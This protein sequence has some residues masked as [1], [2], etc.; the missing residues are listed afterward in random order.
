MARRTSLGFS[1]VEL[2]VALVFTMILMAGMAKVFQSSLSNFYT[3]GE[4]LSS[5]RRNRVALDLVYEDLNS[6][7]MALVDITSPIPGSD[8]N[9]VFYIIPNVSVTGAGTSDPQLTDELYMAYDQPLP[10]DGKLKSGGGAVS[11]DTAASKVLAGGSLTTGTDDAY[12]IDC[13]D[14][15]YAKSVKAGMSFHIKDDMSRA[16]YQIKTAAPASNASHVLIT[17]ET[18]PSITTQVTGRGDPG[19]L[20]STKRIVDSNVVFILPTQ[21]VRYRIAMLKLDPSNANGIPCLVREQGTYVSSAAF[22]PDASLTQVIAENVAGFKA[23]L[24]ADSGA[25][26]AGLTLDSATTG[27]AAGWTGGIQADLNTQLGTVAR[28]DYTTTSGNLNWY[29]DIPVLVRLDI[30]TR[31]ATQRGEYSSTG[32]TLAYKNLTQSVVLVPRHFGL[33]LS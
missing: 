22:T 11:G 32:N 6:A 25:N 10:F 1:L 28:T 24:S 19:T 14:A 15:S 3:S 31:T 7:G 13:N 5:I 2:L 29:R 20:R 12:E 18:A 26:W 8:T 27:F 21:M 9:P 30:T 33:P 16:A 4:K 17:V 23:F